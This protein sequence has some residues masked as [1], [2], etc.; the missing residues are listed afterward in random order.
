MDKTQ[1]VFRAIDL[2]MLMNVALQ[3]N[4]PIK[5]EH[6][7]GTRLWNVGI[8]LP[9]GVSPEE[10][11]KLAAGLWTARIEKPLPK[12]TRVFMAKQEK[13][14]ERREQAAKARKLKQRRVT[15]QKRKRRSK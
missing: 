8:D 3:L 13:L 12:K 1:A 11:R 14:A 2:N 7:A 6:I 4:L 15:K 10:F 5:F 9:D